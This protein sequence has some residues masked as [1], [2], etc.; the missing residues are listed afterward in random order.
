M[1]AVV[2]TSL[3]NKTIQVKIYR[4]FFPLFRK[5]LGTLYFSEYYTA[6]PGQVSYIMITIQ[7]L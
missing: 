2:C 1:R 5:A 4:E 3:E 7:M 6:K